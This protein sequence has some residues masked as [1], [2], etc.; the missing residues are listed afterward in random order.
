MDEIVTD[1]VYLNNYLNKN[2]FTV[3]L[4]NCLLK[5]YNNDFAI[6]I[7]LLLIDKEFKP[8][9][10]IN[11]LY[12][13][14]G[15]SLLLVGDTKIKKLYFSEDFKEYKTINEIEIENKEDIS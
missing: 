1:L 10:G 9:E 15:N 6:R 12:K 4:N 5:I 2:Y 8:D 11:L 14:L 13:S 3:S 7:Q